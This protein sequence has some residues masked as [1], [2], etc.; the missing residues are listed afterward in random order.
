[1]ATTEQIKDAVKLWDALRSSGI[2]YRAAR[3]QVLEQTG[4]DLN[5]VGNLGQY[6][7]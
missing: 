3:R 5:K 2:L 4:V 7:E 1:M 6:R